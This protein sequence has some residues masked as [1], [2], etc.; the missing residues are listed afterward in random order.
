MNS[1]FTSAKG[2]SFSTAPANL[3]RKC[4][5]ATKIRL[6][7][8]DSWHSEFDSMINVVTDIISKS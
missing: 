8:L 6:E 5:A 7:L 2:F 1:A 4:L 3:S